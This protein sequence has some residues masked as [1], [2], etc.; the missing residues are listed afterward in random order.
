[1]TFGQGHDTLLGH[2][3]QLCEILSRSNMEGGGTKSWPRHDVNR[4]TVRQ[5]DR[6]IPINPISCCAFNVYYTCMYIQKHMYPK[7]SRNNFIRDYSGLF[8]N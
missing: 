6:V 2:G 7:K 4:R 1:M 8:N 5:T 3:Q